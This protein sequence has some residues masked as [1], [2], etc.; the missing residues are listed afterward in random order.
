MGD[1]FSVL[2]G[3][4][5]K[6]RGA[7]VKVQTIIKHCEDIDKNNDGIIHRN[8]LE[9]VLRGLLKE[10]MLSRRELNY[11]CN[12]VVVG[13]S[14]SINYNDFYEL[15]VEDPEEVAKKNK[16]IKD[17]EN[18]MWLDDRNTINPREK[19]ATRSGTVGDFI[20]NKS[21][22]AEIKSFKRLIFHLEQYE[23]ETGMKVELQKN[24][25]GFVASIGPDLRA[26]ITFHIGSM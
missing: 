14:M 13:N 19:W 24:G 11:I 6:I 26:T 12:C 8:D 18:E 21:C 2:Q 4:R 23:K 22:P 15:M 17:V 16:K 10:Q 20:F 9:D 1:D 7:F 3:I 25:E 5:Q